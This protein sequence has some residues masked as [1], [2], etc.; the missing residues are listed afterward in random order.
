MINDIPR[1]RLKE[2][3]L[4]SKEREV[5]GPRTICSPPALDDKPYAEPL[6]VDT[7]FSSHIYEP[8]E[9]LVFLM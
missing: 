1:L 4:Q 9:R 7:L 3:Y 2:D 5:P 8:A 6:Q